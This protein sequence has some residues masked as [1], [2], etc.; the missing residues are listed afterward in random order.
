[1]QTFLVKMRF[2]CMRKKK[3]FHINGSALGL[4]FKQRLEAARKWREMTFCYLRFLVLLFVPDALIFTKLCRKTTRNSLLC[5]CSR[6]LFNKQKKLKCSWRF[7]V[8]L[9]RNLL[10]VN[11][12]SRIFLSWPKHRGNNIFNYFGAKRISRECCVQKIRLLQYP[13]WF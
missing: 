9:S 12:W 13:L 11:S 10:F 4:A 8:I 7:D 2:I 6:A 3:H 5:L 1:M